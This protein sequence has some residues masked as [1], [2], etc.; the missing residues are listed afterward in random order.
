VDGC[1]I[2]VSRVKGRHRDHLYFHGPSKVGLYVERK[3][4]LAFTSAIAWYRSRTTVLEEQLGDFDGILVIS[5]EKL[6][7]TFFRGRQR[8]RA[9]SKARYEAPTP[10]LESTFEA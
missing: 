2:A 3:T 10:G 6:P 1:A 9:F 4:R 8:G 5:A 7:R